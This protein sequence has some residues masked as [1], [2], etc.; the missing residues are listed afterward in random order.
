MRIRLVSA[1]FGN[2]EHFITAHLNDIRDVLQ[3]VLSVLTGAA[4]IANQDGEVSTVEVG[5]RTDNVTMMRYESHFYRFSYLTASDVM[6]LLAL[7]PFTT[8]ITGGSS[9]TV[10]VDSLHERN[11]VLIVNQNLKLP[12]RFEGLSI[13]G[14]ITSVNAGFTRRESPELVG[15]RI[16]TPEINSIYTNGGPYD[17]LYNIA[18]ISKMYQGHIISNIEKW[19]VEDNGAHLI[20]EGNFIF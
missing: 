12:F 19:N 1:S 6:W 8:L 3:E 16:S 13:S 4:F 20:F 9:V 17:A 7:Q 10:R 2:V 15:G 14:K 5:S 11:S 18:N